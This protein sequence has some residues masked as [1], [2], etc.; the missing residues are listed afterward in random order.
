MRHLS[1]GES[2]LPP[3][4]WLA[5]YGRYSGRIEKG[6]LVCMLALFFYALLDWLGVLPFE[7][8]WRPLSLVLLSGALVLQS[9]AVLIQRRSI[10]VFV[11]LVA[12]SL[13]LIA[14]SFMVTN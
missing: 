6:L 4:R 11:C 8:G 7:R 3:V 5:A 9:V 12:I 14:A 10:V 2:A 1:N 13:S